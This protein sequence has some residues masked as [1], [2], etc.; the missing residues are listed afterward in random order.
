MVPWVF[1]AG[2]KRPPPPLQARPTNRQI[3]SAVIAR[4][5]PARAVRGSGSSLES[6]RW[7]PAAA[8][9]A[10]DCRALCPLGSTTIVAGS[11]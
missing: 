7:S 6:A 3:I 10:T 2:G 9:A 11:R 5:K 1:Q 8:R 4:C